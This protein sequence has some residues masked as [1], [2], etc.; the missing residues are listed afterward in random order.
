V[1]SIVGDEAG[2]L[3]AGNWASGTLFN[4]TGGNVSVFAQTGGA[5]NHVCY[6]HGYIYIASP[7]SALVR[8]VSVGGAVETFIGTET[9]QIIDGPI[10]GADFE[11]PNSCAF[12]A[13]GTIMYVMEREKGLLRRVD[14]GPP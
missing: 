10:A 12:S 5:S 1:V 3:Y 7:T 9:R 11:R 13:D 8:R 14:A 6:S 2:N 4:I